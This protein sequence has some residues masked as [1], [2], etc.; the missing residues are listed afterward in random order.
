MLAALVR[1]SCSAR[2]DAP[3]ISLGSSKLSPFR[4]RSAMCAA[5]RWAAELEARH[6]TDGERPREAD[7]GMA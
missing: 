5:G 1:V 4:M 3:H 7:G 2:L 6:S